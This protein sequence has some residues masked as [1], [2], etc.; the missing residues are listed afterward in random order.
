MWNGPRKILVSKLDILFVVPIFVIKSPITQS[1]SF[2]FRFL[3]M[4]P[5]LYII[6][7]QLVKSKDEEVMG[8]HLKMTDIECSENPYFGE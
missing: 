4:G 6:N 8:S 5:I 3:G 7:H 1:L 2:E